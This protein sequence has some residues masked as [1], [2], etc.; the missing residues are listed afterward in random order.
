MNVG[1]L[2]H[3]LQNDSQVNVLSTPR[4]MTLDNEEAEIIVGEE[5]PYLKSS[6]TTNF[7]STPENV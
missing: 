6:Q 7:R 3:T 2:L 4:L 1:A 5:R